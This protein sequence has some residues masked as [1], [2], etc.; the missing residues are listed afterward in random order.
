MV[1]RQAIP[2]PF[3]RKTEGSSRIIC[4]CIGFTDDQTEGL[5]SIYTIRTLVTAYLLIQARGYAGECT[6]YQVAT[7]SYSIVCTESAR[8]R[9]L[10]D[11][12]TMSGPFHLVY[13]MCLGIPSIEQV[14]F[15]AREICAP[16]LL[17]LQENM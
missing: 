4:C 10:N 14:K 6:R 5:A 12:S 15:C 2:S 3:P 16:L 9:R 17:V 7:C 11:E 8:P 1:M 13:A